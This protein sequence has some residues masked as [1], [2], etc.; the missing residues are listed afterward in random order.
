MVFEEIKSGELNGP[1][2]GIDLPSFCDLHSASEMGNLSRVKVILSQRGT[3]INC[4]EWIGRTPVMWA[5]GSGHRE[6]VELL[7]SKGA[8]ESIVDRFDNNILHSAGRGGDVEVVQYVLSHDLVDIN[9]R[10]SCR[11]TPVMVAAENGHREIVKLLVDKGGD[12]S[13]VDEKNDNILHLACLCG[14]KEVVKYVLSQDI[15]DIN[16]RGRQTTT[17]VM[18]AARNGHKEVVELL[19]K[20]GADLSLAYNTPGSNV[21]HLACFYGHVDV[22]KYLLSQDTVDVNSRGRYKQTP[23]MRAA[24]NGHKEVVEL[25]VKKGADLSLAYNAD[26]SNV[27]HLA[28]VNGHV[29]VVKY[30]LSQDTVNINS[31]G[32]RKRTPMMRAA[33]EGYKEV[34]ELLVSKG[35]DA[36]LVDKRGNNLLHLA[37]QR[38][39]MELV[40][41]IVSQ[42]MVDINRRGLKKRSPV[43]IAAESGHKEVVELLVNK[44]ADASLMDKKGNNILHLACQ[45]GHVEVVKYVLSQDIVDINSRGWKTKT[46]MMMAAEEGHKEVVELLLNKGTD[47]SLVDKRGNNIL[48]LACQNGQMEVVKY[49]VSKVIVDVNAKNKRR[50]TAAN[51][52]SSQGR[53]DLIDLLVSHG[54]HMS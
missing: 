54:A 21:L 29:D 53:E 35:A 50:K 3:D 49:I 14:Q 44:G 24:K 47:P 17:P 25:L 19:V 5:A 42:D 4:N 2:G 32:W 1:S 34:V 28:C 46:P 12:M 38:G 51:I 43:M 48:H 22:V 27:L 45:M 36:S 31:R 37:C 33:E 20:K 13:L 41:Y 6:V 26:G 16:G 7:V 23:M 8:N 10:G 9:V 39:Q 15:V 40:K 11:R 18:L 52:A 30:L